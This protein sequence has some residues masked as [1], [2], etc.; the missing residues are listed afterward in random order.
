MQL[1]SALDWALAQAKH[2]IQAFFNVFNS[3]L[4]T[5]GGEKFSLGSVTELLVQAL[6]VL[7]VAGAIKQLLKNRILPR[8]GLEIGTRES[9]SAITSYIVTII[10]FLIVLETTG[11]NLSSL[12]V[13]AGGLGIGFGI[14]L[15]NLASNFISGLT[16]LFEQPIKVGDYIEVDKLAGTVE[17]IAIRSSTIRTVNGVFVIVPNSHFLDKNVVNWSY[18]EPNC[19]I[20]IPVRV[21]EESD[22]LTVMEALLT[23]ARQESRVLSTPCPEVYFKGSKKDT[24]RFE[25]L[26]WIQNPADM[27]SLKSALQFLIEAEFRDR[28]IDTKSATTKVVLE[29][30]PTLA[31]LLQLPTL[32]ATNGSTATSALAHSADPTALEKP[33]GGWM[34]RDLLRKVSY[35]QQC[36]DVELRQ[37]I[38]K[39]Y[40]KKLEQGEIICRENDPGDSFYI[41]LSGAVEVFVD[42]FNSAG[43]NKTK[44]TQLLWHGSRLT[45]FV[46]IISQGLRIAPPEA[47]VTGY[48]FGKGVYFAD[49]ISKS[50]NYC[51]ASRGSDVAC[52]LLCEVALGDMN[53]LKQADYHA[54]NLPPGKLST[55]G[56]GCNFP[57][58]AQQVVLDNG[59]IVPLGPEKKT[60]LP[61]SSLLYNEFMSGNRFHTKLNTGER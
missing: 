52:M 5:F 21:V 4:F 33:I 39:G 7:L 13:F 26:V 22:S 50:A 36:G 8:F 23:A 48:M 51:N 9:L 18:S 42:R 17:E 47:P 37:V 59:V 55:K 45:N 15:Q 31:A 40:R 19:R 58:P 2:L 57:D 43:F 34:L 30:L 61:G 56:L 24:L 12:A 29:N 35:F 11:I 10:G 25:L 20:V 3:S 16:L 6:V 28:A 27:D 60:Q 44:N 54:S 53:E 1:Q 14:G 41:I 38:E 46:G 49:M 32:K